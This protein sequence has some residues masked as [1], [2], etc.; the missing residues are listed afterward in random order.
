M[1]MDAKMN[2][3][4]ETEKRQQFFK[5]SG[6]ILMVLLV[7]GT[8]IL[9]L[10]LLGHASE[11][12]NETHIEEEVYMEI[13]TTA[14]S[15][16]Q[17]RAEEQ[18]STIQIDDI[19]PVDLEARLN[20]WVNQTPGIVGLS[21]Y[22][23]TTGKQIGINANQTF[24][25]ASTI[26]LPTHMMIAELVQD[27]VLS[28][29][30]I[31]TV[32]QSDWLGGSGVLQYRIHVGHELTL[33]EAMRYSIIYSD[34]L[35]HRMLTRTLIPDFQHWYYGLDNNHWHLTTEVFNRYL[36]GQIP[37]GRMALS[38]NQ[39]TEIFKVLY[40]DRDQ[41]EGYGMILEH[42]MNTA[43]TD[44]FA[45]SLA[46]GI[47]AHTPAWSYPYSHDSA[48]FFADR[49]YILIVM[50]SGTPDAPNFLSEVSDLVLELHTS[51]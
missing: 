19:T 7:L 18:D 38:P 16:V 30:Q 6:I 2:V 24:F 39:L 27:G 34:N 1:E 22:C 29:D 32:E 12:E 51:R 11:Y 17:T 45:T 43:W 50:T 36:G 48:I 31:L 21:Y 40:R 49:P 25:G 3:R 23:L 44:R 26:K 14:I 37:T 15:T 33:Y 46:D 20:E 4:Y 10:R 42:M 8:L 28:W 13:Q 35:A 5:V 47:V 41:I 9:G